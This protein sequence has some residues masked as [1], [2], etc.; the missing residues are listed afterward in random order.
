MQPTPIT[1]CSHNARD[2]S[3]E[4]PIGSATGLSRCFLIEIPLPWAR[5]PLETPHIPQDVTEALAEFQAE[6]GKVTVTL[7]AP[8]PTYAVDGARLI[9]I[10]VIDGSITKRDIIA[11]DGD[12]AAVIRSLAANAPLPQSATVD[13]TP[14]RDIAVCTHGSRDACC[15]TFGAPMYL[16]MHTAA[17]SLPN[18]RIWRSSHLGGHR[19]A[20]TMI[21]FPSGRSWGLVDDSAARTIMLRD[22]DLSTLLPHYRGWIGHKDAEV[23]MLEAQA[24]TQIGWEWNDWQQTGRV[25]ERDSEGR[26][27]VVELTGTHPA[28]GTVTFLGEIEW[29]EQFG[30]IASCNADPVT[31]V[32]K[33]LVN[34]REREPVG[35][36]A[37]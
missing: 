16:K 34:L 13:D 29:G 23:Q 21:D 37:D 3:Q 7:L 8:D 18:T 28:H 20:P 32:R 17:R 4:A 9:D 1:Y 24:L 36:V 26:G 2:I 30:T 6:Q 19:F 15:A 27:V 33:K 11:T 12:L 14:W 10:Q 35:A 22:A 25:V 31:Y 5:K